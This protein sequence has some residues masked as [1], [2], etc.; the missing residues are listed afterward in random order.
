MTS[1]LSVLQTLPLQFGKLVDQSLQFLKVPQSLADLG[2][3][4][5]GDKQLA[6][7]AV[8]AL[9]QIERFVQVAARATT[10][11]LAASVPADRERATEQPVLMA[12]LRDP[13]AG[14]ALL[15]G[16]MVSVH[17]SYIP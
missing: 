2:L 11:G 16:K 9:D 17:V 7:L 14:L 15:G 4:G 13:G 5:L 8:T 1:L 6:Q 10:G 12:Q 3:P